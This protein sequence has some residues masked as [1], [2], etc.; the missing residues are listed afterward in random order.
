MRSVSLA[1]ARAMRR[2][3]RSPQHTFQLRQTPFCIQPFFIAPVLPGETMKNLLLQARAV[4]DPIRQ[5]LVGWWLEYYFFYVKHRDLSERE[6][7]VQ[8]MLDPTWTIANVDTA[9]ADVL[10]YF[11]GNGINWTK[12]CLDEVVRW[13]FRDE[14]DAGTTFELD[15]LPIASLGQNTWLDSVML[16]SIMDANEP[17]ITVGVDDVITASEIDQTMRQYQ[18]L[19]ANNMVQMSYEDYLK[20]YGIRAPLTEDPHKPELVRFIREWTYPTNTVEPTTGRPTSALSWSVAERADKDRFFSEPGFLFGVSVVRPKVY[21]ANQIGSAVWFM[22]NAYTWL[23][24]VL[25]DDPATSIQVVDG[26][27][28][29]PLT[30]ASANFAVDVRDILIHGDQFLNFTPDASITALEAAGVTSAAGAETT[31]PVLPDNSVPLPSSGLLRKYLTSIDHIK[32]L[33]VPTKTADTP[34]WDYRYYKVRQ[35]GI[36]SL[37]IASSEKDHT[38]TTPNNVN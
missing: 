5:P 16:E 7:F 9:A 28:V 36:V 15:G 11:A 1:P 34:T 8:M 18:F 12:K 23:P 37:Q 24:A 13:Y 6:E 10:T 29:S 27:V 30:I 31:A 14:E 25:R 17:S 22:N 2:S 21:M 20:T 4:S 38:P 33:F 32:Q 35:D 3:I 19:K 26:S